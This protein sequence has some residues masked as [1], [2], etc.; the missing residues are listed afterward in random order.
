MVKKTVFEFQ[1]NEKKRMK[2]NTSA[3]TNILQMYLQVFEMEKMLM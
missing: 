1:E 3:N 2:T